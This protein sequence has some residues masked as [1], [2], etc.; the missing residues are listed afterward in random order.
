MMGLSLWGARIGSSREFGLGLEF[1]FLLVPAKIFFVSERLPGWANRQKMWVSKLSLKKSGW[2]QKVS[3]SQPARGQKLQS[4]KLLWKLAVFYYERNSQFLDFFLLPP[5]FRE[6]KKNSLLKNSHFNFRF[7]VFQG[8]NLFQKNVFFSS[9]FSRSLI[10]IQQPPTWCCP[11]NNPNRNYPEF[12]LCFKHCCCFFL[13]TWRFS[14]KEFLFL[15]GG[16]ENRTGTSSAF[17]SL[18]GDLGFSHEPVCVSPNSSASLWNSTVKKEP[19]LGFTLDDKFWV[20]GNLADLSFSKSSVAS[21]EPLLSQSSS[22][23]RFYFGQ[24]KLEARALRPK[25]QFSYS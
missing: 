19:L 10:S 15:G 18:L 3:F 23:Q 20:K 5:S 14:F 17:L 24:A 9:V 13:A 16:V 11:K 7:L 12:L 22:M 6:L 8:L 25:V 2:M 4:W 1:L 21:S